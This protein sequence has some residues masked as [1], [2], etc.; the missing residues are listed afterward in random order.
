[1]NKI[2]F[3][4]EKESESNRIF[5][6]DLRNIFISQFQFYFLKINNQYTLKNQSI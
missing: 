1:M 4:Q 2:F 5:L 6:N 3:N